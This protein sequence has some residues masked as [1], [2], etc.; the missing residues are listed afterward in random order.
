MSIVITNKIKEKLRDKHCVREDEVGEC[1]ANLAGDLLRDQREDHRSEPPTLWFIAETYMGRKLKVAFI[2]ID[3]DF[4]IRT[5]YEPN[6]EELRIY[7]K[8]RETK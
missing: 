1:F 5:A 8:Y 4:H 6:D 3:G 7:R 2:P